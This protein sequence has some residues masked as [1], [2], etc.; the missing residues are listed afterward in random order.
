[1][2]SR[3]GEPVLIRGPVLGSVK[4]QYA[5]EVRTTPLTIDARG[6]DWF[7]YFNSQLKGPHLSAQHDGM[8]TITVECWP[9][10][11]PQW[12]EKVDAAIQYA[13]EKLR[14]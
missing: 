14:H 10:D 12:I 9:D 3:E 5:Y 6:R 11:E 13:N 4:L 8:K 2:I 1:M 7:G